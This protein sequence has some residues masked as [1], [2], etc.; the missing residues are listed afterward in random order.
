MARQQSVYKLRNHPERQ[1][2]IDAS[3]ERADGDGATIVA[4]VRE[5]G[6]P[7]FTYKVEFSGPFVETK[8]DF[9]AEMYLHTA[10]SVVYSQIESLRHVPTLLRVQAASGLVLTEPLSG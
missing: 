7:P 8:K 4:E 3:V 1:F 2:S 5:A 9:D 6:R 10:L